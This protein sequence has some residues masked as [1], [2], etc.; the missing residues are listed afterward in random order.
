MSVVPS[1][2]DHWFVLCSTLIWCIGVVLSVL[3]EID[4]RFFELL[5]EQPPENLDRWLEAAGLRT[6]STSRTIPERRRAA[7]RLWRALVAAV[8]W[9]I[10]VLVSAM[11]HSF[12]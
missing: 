12:A 9:Q 11:L 3:V 8:G 10:F 2:K 5:A 4:A 6:K 1:W 7:L